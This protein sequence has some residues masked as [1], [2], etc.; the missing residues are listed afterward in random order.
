MRPL[1]FGVVFTGGYDATSWVQLARRVEDTGFSTLLVAD[2]YMNPMACGPLL[3]AAA[4][5]TTELRIGSYVYNNDFRAPALLA[6]EAAT[7]DVLSDGRFELGL[8]AGWAKI[9]YVLAGLRFDPPGVRADRL[10]EAV[11]LIRSLLAGEQV[12]HRGEHYRLR[13]LA[14]SPAGV[15]Q[16]VPLLVGGGG[17][18]MTR[19][20][21]RCA[22]I[23]GF[24]PRSL[25]DGGIDPAGFTEQAMDERVRWLED[26]LDRTD[27]SGD[28]PERSVLVFGVGEHTRDRPEVASL[29]DDQLTDSPHLLLGGISQMAEAVLQ[30]AERWGLTYTVCFDHDLD[31]FT[32]LVDRLT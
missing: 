32:P 26:E 5:A 8:G 18:R 14:G 27:R 9:E 3:M 25:P 4:A 22:D 17:P 13:G 16:P 29:S 1:R 20:A 7:I 31:A 2:H 23:V 21:A 24:V 6:K 12:D 10:E 15:Q 30:R 19:F 28:G 11:P